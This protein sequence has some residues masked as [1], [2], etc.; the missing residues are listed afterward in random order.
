MALEPDQYF[1]RPPGR[2]YLAS[3]GVPTLIQLETTGDR[4]I[5]LA[6]FAVA[7]SLPSIL[8]HVHYA[9]MNPT[10]FY[11]QCFMTDFV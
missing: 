6:E 1:T 2:G 10:I 9:L 7:R 3:T 4:L 8:H 11:D 5:F